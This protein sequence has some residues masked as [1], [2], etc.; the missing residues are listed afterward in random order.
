VIWWGKVGEPDLMIVYN[1]HWES[2][3]VENLAN[4]SKGNWKVLARSWFGD[5][6]DLCGPA[7]WQTNCPDAGD[8]IEVKGRSMA[9]LISD[10]D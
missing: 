1:E 3:A 2:F 8:H 10:N 6:S 9:V 7:D 4:W 5:Q